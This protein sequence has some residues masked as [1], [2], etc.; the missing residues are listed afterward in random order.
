MPGVIALLSDIHGNLDALTAVLADA[1]ARGVGPAAIYCLGDLV[2]YGADSTTC[3][4]MARGFAGAVRGNFEVGL[5][6]DLEGA[7]FST[8]VEASLGRDQLAF[9][10]RPE[11]RDFLARLPVALDTTAGFRLVHGTPP[12]NPHEYLFPECVHNARKMARLLSEAPGVSFVGHTHV[13]GVFCHDG[14]AWEYREVPPVGRVGLTWPTAI[15][16]VG[17]VGQ[18]R[19]GDRR[20]SYVLLDG[21]EVEFRRVEY[22][23]ESAMRRIRASGGFDFHADRLAEGR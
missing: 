3:V 16:N 7:G 11:L 21:R 15:V 10:D 2:G 20:A 9:A 13:P 18:P 5:L 8:G 12:T 6:G 17:S 4:E 1:D 14:R 19:D 22:D 23:V